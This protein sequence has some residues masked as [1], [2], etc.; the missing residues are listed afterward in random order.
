MRF[1]LWGSVRPWGWEQREDILGWSALLISAMV[2]QIKNWLWNNQRPHYWINSTIDYYQMS[3]T[4]L[5]LLFTQFYGCASMKTPGLVQE[6][7]TI[8][9]KDGLN[10]FFLKALNFT[11]STSKSSLTIW[12]VF[13][14]AGHTPCHPIF[15]SSSFM[16]W[17]IH[18][19]IVLVECQLDEYE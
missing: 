13:S 1:I 2:S 10:T 12:K 11:S 7:K 6:C 15:V 19:L 4:S 17:L 18:W 16:D 5:I 14:T 3:V 8:S 9:V